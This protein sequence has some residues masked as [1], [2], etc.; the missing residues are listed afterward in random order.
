MIKP[1]PNRTIKI[2]VPWAAGGGNVG[3]AQ[4]LLTKTDRQTVWREYIHH[5]A[6]KLFQIKAN[7]ANVHQRRL[8]GRLFGLN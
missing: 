4:Y 8:R 5:D 3:I 1:I 6:E 2:I 7:S